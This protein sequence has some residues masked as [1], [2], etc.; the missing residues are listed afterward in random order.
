M[1]EKE[2][3]EIMNELLSQPSVRKKVIKM[4]RAELEYFKEALLTTGVF[5]Q[6][7]KERKAA[8]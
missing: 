7:C 3:E 5:A 6:Y 8:K 1:S 2:K 4:T